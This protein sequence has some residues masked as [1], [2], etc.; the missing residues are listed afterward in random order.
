VVLSAPFHL[1]LLVDT[2]FEPVT[3]KVKAEP[4]AY[5]EV[6]LILEIDGTMGAAV[7]VKVLDPEIPPPGVGL[8][9]VIVADPADIM[10]VEV[11]SAFSWVDET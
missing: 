7:I 10:S 2:K 5:P 8:N 4:P 11:I 6:G 3:V 1:I 9:T